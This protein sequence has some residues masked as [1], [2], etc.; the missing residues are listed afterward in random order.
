VAFADELM[1][2]K[3]RYKAPDGD[4]S[5]LVSAIVRTKPQTMSANLGFASAVAELGL[6]LR[7]SQFQG[8]SSFEGLVGRARTFR[9]SDAEG[10]RSEFIRLAE[11]ASSLKSLDAPTAQSRR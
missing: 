4:A 3:L 5:R 9:G 7:G 2:V 1:T 6:L 11:T 8:T 10:Y